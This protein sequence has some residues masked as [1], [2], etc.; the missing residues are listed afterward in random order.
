MEVRIYMFIIDSKNRIK[1]VQGDTAIHT[2]ETGYEL[3]VGDKVELSV[4]KAIGEP[5]EV[6]LVS[7]EFEG[8]KAI[9][10]FTK[11][12][13]NIAPGE[14]LYDIQV[15]ASNSE[16]IDTIVTPTKLT[17]IGGITQ[18]KDDTSGGGEAA[19]KGILASKFAFGFRSATNVG[20]YGGDII[21]LGKFRIYYWDG[22]E[23]KAL[24]HATFWSRGAF[25]QGY[26]YEGEYSYAF[27][28][29]DASDNYSG[30]GFCHLGT[31]YSHPL[32][33][34]S[35]G[36]NSYSEIRNFR[37]LKHIYSFA[38]Y[39]KECPVYDIVGIEILCQGSRD[40]D[41]ALDFDL[42]FYLGG[43]LEKPN[44]IRYADGNF[45]PF[46]KVA[47]HN[48][49]GFPKFEE[50]KL[51]WFSENVNIPMMLPVLDFD[52]DNVCPKYLQYSQELA[53]ANEK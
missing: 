21:K 41:N 34:Y 49:A 30:Q 53:A 19:A 46:Q 29:F 39:D 42:E 28:D 14:Y 2:I 23:V 25:I 5:A 3:Q 40:Y 26:D 48:F 20:N 37:N 22:K 1:L 33:Q 32:H 38:G 24:Q 35:Y 51:C 15:T 36:I 44:L 27:T 12:D 52:W 13:T 10:R 17:V 8:S 4:A 7:H 16:V 47:G 43:D 45:V 11:E 18:P 31:D 50:Y 9:F 6:S